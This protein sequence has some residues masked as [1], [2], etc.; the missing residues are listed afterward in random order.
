MNETILIAALLTCHNRKNKTISALESLYAAEAF[1]N[2]T[3]D[4]DVRIDVFLTDDGCVDGTADAVMHNADNHK[5]KIIESDGN[6]YWAGG[7]RIAWKEAVKT[8]EYPFYLLINDDVIIKEDCL[9]ELMNTHNYCCSKYH[10][11]GVYT[12]FLADPLNKEKITYGAEVYKKGL[13]AST[14]LLKPA[15]EPQDC[16]M[17]NANILF[18]N[19]DVVK[20]IGVLSDDYVHGAADWDYGMRASKA[21]FPVLTTS[22]VAG[23]CSNDHDSRSKEAAKVKAMSIRERVIFLKRPT[24]HYWDGF[25]F[26]SKYNKPRW[27]LLRIAY[28]MNI[29][30]PQIYYYLFTK[31]NHK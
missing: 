10:K 29:Y 21:G 5:I 25:T 13:F 18:V 9:S 26:F 11:A 14:E 2:K 12:A 23:Y 4:N 6:S 19:S 30:T 24:K 15:G 28:Y 22:N 1:Y 20:S 31:R 27:V 17:P 7:M 3:N 8:G 16:T